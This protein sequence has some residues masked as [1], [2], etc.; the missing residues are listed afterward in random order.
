MRL[1]RA[2]CRLGAAAACTRCHLARLGTPSAAPGGLRHR[3][4]APCPAA[5]AH[6]HPQRPQ[7]HPASAPRGLLPPGPRPR[8]STCR[9]SSRASSSPSV[10]SAAAAPSPSPAPSAAAAA[11]PPAAPNAMAPGPASPARDESASP[12]LPP[13]LSLAAD[14]PPSTSAPTASAPA[15]ADRYTAAL[16]AAA[17]AGA[18]WSWP[19]GPLAAPSSSSPSSSPP[20]QPLPLPPGPPP[21]RRPL[22]LVSDLDDTLIAGWGWGEA[23][24][25][26][27]RPAC[28]AA[29]AALVAA[30]DHWRGR[31]RGQPGGGTGAGNGDG[32]AFP[33]GLAVNTGRTLPL[34]LRVL[35]ERGPGVVPVPDVLCAGVGSRVYL[36]RPAGGPADEPSGWEEHAGWAAAV[37][38]EWDVGAVWRGVEAARRQLG[39]DCLQLRDP[40]ECDALKAT[41]AAPAPCL[42]PLLGLLE[43]ALGGE[44]VRYR[45]VIGPT[46]PAGWAY[47]DVLP[48]RAG[49]AAA[50]A[51]VATHVFGAGG[52]GRPGL[53]DMVVAGDAPNDLD[54]L[55]GAGGGGGGRGGEGVA[56]GAAIAVANCSP[57]IKQA[58][59]LLSNGGRERW[60]GLG[61]SGG[62]S[63]G[64]GAD[65]DGGG[66]PPLAAPRGGCVGAAVAVELG[67]GVVAGVVAALGAGRGTAGPGSEVGGAGPAGGPTGLELLPPP[68]PGLRLH[69]ASRPGAAGV[70]EGLRALGFC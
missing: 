44:G 50:A 53:E 65:G 13:P 34:F 43:G 17:A 10:L 63:G 46:D 55:L 68:T 61:R 24:R 57:T 26:E 40:S 16:E 2:A 52:G 51:F 58:V 60:P 27:L 7:Q 5:P 41:L 29:S 12:P 8:S 31:G 45:L 54:M 28:D 21:L 32:Q 67:P 56:G 49:K 62:G 33:C 22:L 19:W 42:P 9:C 14:A 15:A 4:C 70:M 47:V 66:P 48:A 1:A 23:A 18:P 69:L 35:R 20:L 39:E 64:A 37:A 6:C 30:L 25:P 11:A 59:A 38:A 3:C 36:R